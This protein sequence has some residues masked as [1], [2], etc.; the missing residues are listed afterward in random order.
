MAA[1]AA[2]QSLLFAALAGS[3]GAMAQRLRFHRPRWRAVLVLTV[4]VPL[5]VHTL[6]WCV[7]EALHPGGRRAGIFLSWV[8]SGLSMASQWWLMRRGL[9]LAGE[10]GQ[11][12]WRDF[13]RL[14][15]AVRHLWVSQRRG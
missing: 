14:P 9:F 3:T 12:Y 7:H 2:V 8:Q 15:E 10:G 6:E 1:G 13:M 11:P 5:V 4:L